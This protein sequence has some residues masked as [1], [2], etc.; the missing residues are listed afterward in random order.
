MTRREL[1]LTP[2]MAA[3]GGQN[4]DW[5]AKAEQLKPRLN[6]ARVRAAR[7]VKPVADASALN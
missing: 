2:A 6:A 4:D 5:V 7:V 3:A 1:L